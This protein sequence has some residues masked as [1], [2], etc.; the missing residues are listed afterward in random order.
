MPVKITILSDA[1]I[2][3][4]SAVAIRDEIAKEFDIEVTHVKVSKLSTRQF[5]ALTKES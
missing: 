1:D 4:L 3:N 5:K 2:E